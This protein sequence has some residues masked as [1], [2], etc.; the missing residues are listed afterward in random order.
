MDPK[1]EELNAIEAMI[2]QANANALEIGQALRSA[3]GFVAKK[4]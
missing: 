2:I 1:V 3:S 4:P